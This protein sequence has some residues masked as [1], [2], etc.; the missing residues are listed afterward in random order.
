MTDVKFPCV[1]YVTKKFKSGT[2]LFSMNYVGPENILTVL[3]RLTE[4]LK[5]CM[6]C[7]VSCSV[8]L[9]GLCA[10]IVRKKVL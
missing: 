3:E 4:F 2:K 7:C 8:M 5:V 1:T 6:L 10:Q 9:Y